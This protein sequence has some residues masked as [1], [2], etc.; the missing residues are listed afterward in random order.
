MENITIGQIALA[1]TFILSIISNIKGLI[2]EFNNP[3]DKKL[4]KALKPV[5]DE[6]SSL[7]TDFNNHIIDSVKRDLVNLMCLA[8]Q[9]VIT[10][11]QKKL[12]HELYDVYTGAGRN[13]Y[14]HDKWERL[15]KE[16]LI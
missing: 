3:I 8:E 4:E 9:K 2:K 15:R 1:L 11:E 7:K 12:A 13:S 6:I 16:G 14:V 5:K 10:E